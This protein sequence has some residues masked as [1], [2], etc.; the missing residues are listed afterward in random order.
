MATERPYVVGGVTTVQSGDRESRT[1]GRRGAG[2]ERQKNH[3][4]SEMQKAEVVLGV[5]R[6]RGGRS[7]KHSPSDTGRLVAGAAGDFGQGC[8]LTQSRQSVVS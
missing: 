2:D 5:L 6:E 3:E 4:V 7:R 8:V 1:T